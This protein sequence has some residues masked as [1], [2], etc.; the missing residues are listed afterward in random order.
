MSS[1]VLFPA[2]ERV[3]IDLTPYIPY[4]KEN[5]KQGQYNRNSV[6]DYLAAKSEFFIQVIAKP[7]KAKQG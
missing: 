3:G 4:K 2:L 1:T 5:G 6:I 7:G